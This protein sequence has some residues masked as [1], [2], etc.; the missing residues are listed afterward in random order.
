[1][2]RPTTDDDAS[3]MQGNGAAGDD[4]DEPS[5]PPLAE[6]I[7][8]AISGIQEYQEE[9]YLP[10]KSLEAP[11]EAT[12]PFVRAPGA[13]PIDV[14]SQP[15][16]P[17][18]L[19]EALQF[20]HYA[21]RGETLLISGIT[22]H[23][24]RLTF[25][26]REDRQGWYVVAAGRRRRPS[27]RELGL[28]VATI[29]QEM[30]AALVPDRQ[31]EVRSAYRLAVAS[32]QPGIQVAGLEAYRDLLLDAA[33]EY[34]AEQTER[35][36]VACV[37]YQAF[38]RFANRHGHRI[39]AAFVQA[40]GERL[41]SMFADAGGVHA[42]HKSG[43]QFRIVVVNHTGPQIDALIDRITSDETRAWLVE[44]VWG[45]AARTHREEV[46]FHIGFAT[47]YPPEREDDPS[48]LAQRLSDDAYRASKLGQLKGQT[49][50]GVAE[51]EYRTTVYRWMVSSENEL[52]DLSAV[53][54][55]GPAEVM[56]EMSDYLHE[57]VP[58]GL[59]GMAVAGDLNALVFCAIAREGFWQG[60]TAMRIAGDR[61]I[62]R[63]LDDAPA[64]EEEQEAEL[65]YVGGFDLG[66]EFYGIAVESDTL[67]FA[68]GDINSAGATRLRA[69]LE[70]VQQ[71]VGWNREDG[72]GVAGEFVGALASADSDEPLVERIRAAAA[73]TF[74]EN[75]ADPGLRVNDAVDLAD[76]LYTNEGEQAGSEDLVEGETLRLVLPGEPPREVQILER[77]SAFSVRLSIEGM[78]LRAVTIGSGRGAPI[79]IRIRNS[80]P[81]AAICVLALSRTELRD[82]MREV[83]EDN[84]LPEDRPMDLVGFLRHI[85]DILLEEQVKR[86]GK[87]RMALGAS[88]D[89]KEFVGAFTLEDVREDHPGLFYEAV[90]RDLL[91]PYKLDLDRQLVDLVGH[92]MLTSARPRR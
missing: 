15:H 85:G 47:A 58:V 36:A 91:S 73:R 70:R 78:M 11:E 40:L 8:S 77:R 56:A 13:E 21:R 20:V 62:R 19:G 46:N 50:I 26:Q 37:S 60:T 72:G 10:L 18:A 5:S 90:H 49:S 28:V 68:R 44:R 75:N 63:V 38:K 17:V 30:E 24:R 54:D 4:T 33:A 29:T 59:E 65:S 66:D 7:G 34:C 81:S 87:V 42:F 14:Q 23:G 22:P 84:G 57:L 1:M 45:E 31:T 92:T 55:D 52:Q 48:A 16:A 6:T 12:A 64:V 83:R 79:K 53:M 74:A 35:L 76:Y 2:T 88:Y 69:G 61:L 3:G 32:D 43:K 82:V 67:Y 89:A 25:E 27:E 86:P 9:S 71:A 80:V 39:G 41:A 51:S